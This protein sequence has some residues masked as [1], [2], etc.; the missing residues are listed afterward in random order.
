MD[1]F[2]L[3]EHEGKPVVINFWFP[4]CPPCRAEIPNFEHAYQ[5]LGPP[6]TNQIVFV[7]V[8][9]VGF[10]TAADGVEFLGKMKANLSRQS[11]TSAALSTSHTKSPARRLRFF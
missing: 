11:Q 9:A 10:D 2:D 7:G 1:R 4:S 8:Q 6:G 5:T 3:A